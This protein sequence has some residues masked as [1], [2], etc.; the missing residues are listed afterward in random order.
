MKWLLRI[1]NYFFSSENKALSHRVRNITGITPA[2]AAIYR[3]AFNHRAGANNNSAKNQSNE[4]LEYLGDAVLSLVVGEYLFQKYPY[5]NEGFLTK[6]RARIVQRKSLNTLAVSLQ[7]DEIMQEYNNTR[8]SSTML[9]NAL[10]ALVGA[11]YLENGFDKTKAFIINKIL[12]PHIDFNLLE[13]HDDNYKSRLL[14]YC[15]KENKHVEYQLLQKTK[16][17]K[18]DC[19]KVAVLVDNVAYGTAEEYNKKSAEQ[20]ASQKALIK[21][22]MLPGNDASTNS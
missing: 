3:M 14:E 22:G 5:A 6:I 16:L 19:F 1:F 11:I 17:N 13:T 10:E 20:I 15:Q 7:L 4:R 2:N 9:G 8:I 21:F 12:R 18:R